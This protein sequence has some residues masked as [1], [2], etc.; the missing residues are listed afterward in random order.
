M[1]CTQDRCVLAGI[2]QTTTTPYCQPLLYNPAMR[3]W[4]SARE[5]GTGPVAK[6][7]R[8]SFETLLSPVKGCPINY[9]SLNDPLEGVQ[10]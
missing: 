1:R 9:L 5:S 10:E 3:G 2:M 7:R 8:G 4:Y 6:K